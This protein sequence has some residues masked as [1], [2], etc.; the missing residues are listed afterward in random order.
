MAPKKAMKATGHDGYMTGRTIIK[1]I[2][3]K[4]ELK[5]KAVKSV[6]AELN[7]IAYKE[8]AETEKFR[9]PQLVQIRVR[10]KP[11][12]PYREID[13][14]GKVTCVKAK[15]AICVVKAFAHY[16]AKGAARHLELPAMKAKP[17]KKA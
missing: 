6:L 8:L 1:T 16:H 15:P 10:H 14:F 3:A 12:T 9:I 13:L 2:A 11:A 7:N 4:T 17:A 5:P